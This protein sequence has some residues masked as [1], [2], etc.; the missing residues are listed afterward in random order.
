MPTVE[1]R[2]FKKLFFLSKKVKTVPSSESS[3][4]RLFKSH[5]PDLIDCIVIISWQKESY[6]HGKG[7]SKKKYII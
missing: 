4:I 5:S 7:E 2:F 3:L 1:V 6:V